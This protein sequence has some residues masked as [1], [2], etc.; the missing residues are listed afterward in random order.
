MWE[1]IRDVLLSPNVTIILCFVV[2]VLLLGVVLSKTGLLKIHTNA[3]EIG[4]ADRERNIIR[5][6]LEWIRLHLEG[7]ESTMPKPPRYDE[8]RGKYIVSAVFE[9][10]VAWITLNHLNTSTAY[11]EIKQD[12][13]VSLVHSLTF[14]EEFRSDEF[15]EF[16]RKT[17]KE[18]IEKLVQI[19][20]V[21]K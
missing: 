13:I 5:Q 20:S 17:T 10:Y 19:R 2:F 9:E 4:A 16:L 18:N 7:L 15:D 21:Y 6:Q 11:I 1:A 14:K 3:L 12:R 8:W